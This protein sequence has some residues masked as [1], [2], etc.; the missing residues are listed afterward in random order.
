MRFPIATG[1]T[2]SRRIVGVSMVALALCLSTF[3][4]GQALIGGVP[5]S[6]AAETF[7]LPASVPDPIE[8]WNRM[9]WGLNKSVMIGVVRPT[10]KVY[11]FVVV[12]PV[13]TGVG[14][15]GRNLTYPGRAINNLLQGKWSGAR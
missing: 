9:M 6:P 2:P 13:R 7:V 1:S 14:N 3:T 11:R 15:F 4:H 8:P 5:K 12:K 10:S